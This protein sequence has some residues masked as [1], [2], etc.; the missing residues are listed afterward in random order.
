MHGET[1]HSVTTDTL[2]TLRENYWILKGRQTVKKIINSCVVCNKL[3]G[4]PYSSTVPPDLPYF[5]TSE[6]TP[7]CHTGIDFAG[8]LYAKGCNGSEKAY[9]CLF[10]CCSTRA[11]HLELTP[12]LSVNSF[13]LSFR[14]FVGRRG[15]PITLVSDNAKTFR[16]SSKEILNITRSSEVNDY[17]SSRKVTWKF[18]V[19]RA[20]WWGGFYERLVRS[21][22]RS[23]K[24][25]LGRSSLT[26]DQLATLIVEIEGIINSRPLTYLADDQDGISG[27][28]SPS[29]LINGRRLTTISNDEHFEIVSTH[30]SLAKRLK[31]HRHLLGQFTN[32]WRRDYLLN[33]RES[34]NL[35]VKKGG[36]PLINRGDV[37]I[38][39]QDTSKRIFW[40]L[41]VVDELLMGADGHVRAAVVRVPE[42]QG[43]TKLLR[44]S[45]K[46]LFPIE[47]RSGEPCNDSSTEQSQEHQSDI[48]AG[49][50]QIDHSKPATELDTTVPGRRPRR[51]AAIVGEHQ[52]RK[53]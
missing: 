32:Q 37:V 19:E 38:L 5:R 50:Q 29:H 6:D 10:T 36:Q 3:E 33:L 47:V 24:K 43:G 34:H 20:P 23:L 25:S 13:L 22:K 35:R 4:L 46:H 2:S 11:V 51:Q 52:R 16:T 39:K 28:L 8:P 17:L 44:R 21:V 27:S 53:Q 15:L 31:Q 18:I 45:V 48:S 41:A 30:Q 7:F 9:I 49:Q 14:R 26:Y 12:D 40:K 1:K 42:P